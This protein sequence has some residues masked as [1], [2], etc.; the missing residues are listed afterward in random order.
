MQ[1]SEIGAQERFIAK[2]DFLS[3][4][5]ATL[6]LQSKAPLIAIKLDKLQRSKRTHGTIILC[7]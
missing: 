6:K 2:S 4:A 5:D 7:K 1:S 3:E